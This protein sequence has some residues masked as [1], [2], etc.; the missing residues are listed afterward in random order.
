[1]NVLTLADSHAELSIPAEGAV[2]GKHKVAQA[3]E[4]WKCFSLAPTSDDQ[5]RDFCQPSG[6]QSRN[7]IRSQPQPVD[8]S[9][10][11]GNDVLNS[12]C[13][14]HADQIGI[15]VKTE[16]RGR[17]FLLKKNSQLLIRRCHDEC[18]GLASC[19]FGREC[20]T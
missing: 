11:N 19:N 15:R 3:C 1:M 8:D 9:G 4:T 16:S 6:D 20:G 18:C 7:G 17:E 12:S 10:S 14:F 2:R 13:N 5:A